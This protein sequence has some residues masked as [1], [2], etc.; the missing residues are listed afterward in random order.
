MIEETSGAGVD[1]PLSSQEKAEWRYELRGLQREFP[2]VPVQQI[3]GALLEALESTSNGS[4][5][6]VEIG[7]RSSLT[8]RALFPG[9]PSA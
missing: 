6:D 4:R 2:S 7:A 8:F 1:R 9:A 5:Q 3:E